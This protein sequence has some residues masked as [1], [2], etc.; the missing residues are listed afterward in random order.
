MTATEQPQRVA[1]LGSLTEAEFR[2]ISALCEAGN[3]TYDAAA[4]R[5]RW[6]EDRAW[7]TSQQ[8]RP[9]QDSTNPYLAS[10]AHW[11]C[12]RHLDRHPDWRRRD[13]LAHD[14]RTD[15]PRY[16]SDVHVSRDAKGRYQWA[17]DAYLR[18]YLDA[19]TFLRE[20]GA[21]DEAI[22]AFRAADAKR[23]ADDIDDRYYGDDWLAKE[24][25]RLRKCA[26]EGYIDRERWLLWHERKTQRQER[27]RLWLAQME[28]RRRNAHQ[29]TK[30]RE[31]KETLTA[32]RKHLR[33]PGRFPLPESALAK[34]SPTS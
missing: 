26:R 17:R 9:V 4:M 28:H 31:G 10:K 13:D 11:S 25:H 20:A 32:L 5:R 34:T 2:L 3:P 27:Q 16:G 23:R 12:A 15:S 19:R 30:L 21:F 18:G 6:V 33:D 7:L 1:K 14:L 24:V 29:L 8:D 22:H